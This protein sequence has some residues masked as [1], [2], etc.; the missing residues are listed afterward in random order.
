MELSSL[1]VIHILSGL[2][3]GGAESQLEKII[4]YSS[5]DS[6]EHIIISLKNDQTP[7]MQRFRANNITVHCLGFSGVDSLYGFVKLVKLLRRLNTYETIIQCWMYHANFFG[8]LAAGCVGLSKKVV[9]NIRRSELP[10][11]VTGILSK[12]SAKLSNMLPVKIV[13]CADAAK[14]SHIKVGYNSQNMLVIHN[15]IDTT[16][17]K[18]NNEYRINFR[19]EI[20]VTEN[21]FVIGMVGRYAPIKGHVY[22]LQ[23]FESLLTKYNLVNIKL[24]I[25][26][27]D[28][29]NAEP[30]QKLLS[31]SLIKKN[32]ILLPERADISEI[33][34]GFDLLCLPSLSEGFPNVVAEAMASGVPAI[35][36]NVGDAAV[37]VGNADMV[38][39][40]A[41][42]NKMTEKLSALIK[43]SVL[44]N[45]C[46]CHFVRERVVTHFSIECAWQKYDKLYNQ[47]IQSNNREN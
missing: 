26:G 29:E 3:Q 39:P 11:G 27:R 37:I 42:V 18:P 28:I 32:L 6:V 16:L 17:F 23:A 36:T 15:G 38:I 46:A 10:K 33:M 21:E 7:L 40:P 41:Q 12:L 47:I 1:R 43:Q 2:Y 9:W 34:M 8:L 30:L 25:V 20:N 35:V 5:S 24:V 4:S 19:K 13:C 31:T 44:E 45:E 22:L 14:K